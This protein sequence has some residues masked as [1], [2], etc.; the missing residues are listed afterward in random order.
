MLAWAPFNWYDDDDYDDDDYDD[1]DGADDDDENELNSTLPAKLFI[2]KRV[3]VEHLFWLMA[4][5]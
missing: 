2:K 3:W 1:N 4:G 5:L